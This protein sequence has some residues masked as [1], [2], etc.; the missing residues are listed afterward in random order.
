M[1]ARK[2]LRALLQLR[3]AR[4]RVRDLVDMKDQLLHRVA[5]LQQ[6]NTWYQTSLEHRIKQNRPTVKE[7]LDALRYRNREL[8]YLKERVNELEAELVETNLGMPK[9]EAEKLVC[10]T[11]REKAC[12][13]V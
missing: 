3:A 6:E 10:E 8:L 1:Y 13:H 7:I 9:H 5:Q 11:Q 4:N 2:Y 12:R